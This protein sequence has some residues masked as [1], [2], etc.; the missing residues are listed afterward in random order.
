M[1]LSGALTV[2]LSGLQTS[3]TA[4]QVISGNISNSQTQGYTAKTINLEAVTSGSST[5]GVEL[6]GYSRVTNN[7]LSATL[8][9]A[10]S[11]AS[12]LSTQNGYM[13]QVQSILNSTNNPPVLSSDLSN[14]QAAWTQYAASPS[15]VTLEKT[16]VSTGQALASTIN[17][18]AVQT[19]SLQ[20]N[21][22]NDLS[23]AVQSLNTA[24][25]E[26]QTLNT[27]ITSARVNKQPTVNL[28]DLR[29]QAINTISQYTNVTVMQRS[30]G[31]V[32]LY[33]SS[34]AALV[35]GLAQTFSVSVD[36]NSILNAVGADAS[37]SLTGGKLQATTDFLSSAASTSNGVGVIT[38][39]QSQLQ[40]FAN[41]F[42]A[43]T[44]TN[45][46]SF[47]DTYNSAATKTGEQGN[48]FFT[49]SINADGLPDMTTFSVNSSLA[50]GTT[51]AKT[52]AAS[53]INNAFSATNLAI[54]VV[55]GSPITYTTSSTF[56]AA[57]LTTQHQT[58]AGIATAI[59]S[60]FQQ[61]AN[62]IQTQNT[63]AAAQKTYYQSSLSSQTGVNTDTELVNLT[64]WENSY[65]AS[66]HVIS[67]IQTMMKTLEN[68]VG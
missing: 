41:L 52:A 68:M 34:G 66:A 45:S 62:A 21:V 22:Q 56:L 25:A 43:T 55:P 26:V 50:N 27:E 9:N 8:N 49:A 42:L 28:E 32:A 2:A 3:T 58:Y 60:G 35:D 16:V 24:L 11:N 44:A 59:L 53:G 47:A 46:G 14:F 37:S 31:Q 40:N 64:N 1:S 33:T 6:S 39:L 51:T 61:A 23:T 4:A 13:T 67:T 57:G 19:T 5:G 12:F 36:G 63:T 38:K 18:I 48:S 10:T 54:T 30:N 15:D 17:S 65:A 7:I 29:D 20:T